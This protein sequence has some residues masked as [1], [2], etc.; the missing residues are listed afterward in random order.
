MKSS[1]GDRPDGQA[2]RCRVHDIGW[3]R[4]PDLGGEMSMPWRTRDAF[5]TRATTRKP[6]RRVAAVEVGRRSPVRA[7]PRPALRF[8][9]G[10]AKELGALPGGDPQRALN[11]QV[12]GE[13][14]GAGSPPSG[15]SSSKAVV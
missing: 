5:G 9:E 4:V 7:R 15:R 3:N 11:A 6:W 2:A 10:A 1:S 12:S 8:P 14:P 13:G